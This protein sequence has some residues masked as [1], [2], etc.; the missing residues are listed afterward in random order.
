MSENI[1][2]Q[3]DP[4][5]FES[6]KAAVSSLENADMLVC[7]ADLDIVAKRL[8]IQILKHTPQLAIASTEL[9]GLR[10]LAYE[11]INDKRFFDWE[12]PTLTGFTADQFR[13]IIE[14]LPKV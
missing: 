7:V 10:S 2:K 6:V 5:I 4:F 14:K 12:M 11:A 13:T 1:A 3:I 9:S 8:A